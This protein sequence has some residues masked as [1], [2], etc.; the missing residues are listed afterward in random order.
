MQDVFEET[1]NPFQP[2]RDT[3]TDRGEEARFFGDNT[4]CLK[5]AMH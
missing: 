1:W 5:H 2:S 3:G 4:D